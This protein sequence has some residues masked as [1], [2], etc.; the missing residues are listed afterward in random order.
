MVDV[1]NEFPSISEAMMPTGASG[2]AN[3]PTPVPLT[4]P[5]TPITKGYT[6]HMEWLFR[7]KVFNLS[8]PL[9]HSASGGSFMVLLPILDDRILVLN[10]AEKYMS[11]SLAVNM[12]EG[13][14]Q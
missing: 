13:G 11:G 10:A 14:N 8:R 9:Q 7:D 12:Q 4:Q 3:C 2:E 6:L 1:W 5:G